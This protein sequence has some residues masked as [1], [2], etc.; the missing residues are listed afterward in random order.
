MK[1]RRAHRRI[2]TE[3][4]AVITVLSSPGNPKLKSKSV[5]CSTRELSA[6]GLRLWARRPI[7][8]G[9]VLELSVEFTDPEA[10]FKHAGKVMW[11]GVERDGHR[12]SY[13]AGVR[14]TET[15]KGTLVEWA[16]RL[17]GVEPSEQAQ[18]RRGRRPAGT[19]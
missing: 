15:P 11:V 7:S 16:K 14:F 9:S 12:K 19:E 17:D 8:V 5:S 18:Q 13:V 4:K 1:E 6:G 10:V 3:E 2:A